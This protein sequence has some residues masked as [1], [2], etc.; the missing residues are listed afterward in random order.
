M[1][2]L[3]CSLYDETVIKAILSGYAMYSFE[4]GDRTEKFFEI[5]NNACIGLNK[6]KIYEKIW[7]TGLMSRGLQGIK[8]YHKAIHEF[9]VAMELSTWDKGKLVAWLDK[10]VLNEKY[11]EVLC[12]LTG[13]ISNQQEQ[14]YILDYLETHNLKLFI[15][16]LKSRRNFD[17]VEMDLNFEYA[18][19][20][21]TQILKTYDDV[22]VE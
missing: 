11:E 12:Y 21:Y 16:A 17:V 13:I 19:C 6:E 9:F 15:K 10:N 14:N 2:L 7:K 18:Q 8:Y 4:N 20:Y 5:L 3:S 22:G 1:K